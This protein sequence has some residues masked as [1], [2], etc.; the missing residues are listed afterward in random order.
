MIQAYG[1]GGIGEVEAALD[2]FS[3]SAAETRVR[4]NISR[5]LSEF[6]FLLVKSTTASFLGEPVPNALSHLTTLHQRCLLERPRQ[7]H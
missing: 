4:S 7:A 1:Q 5:C 2:H 6:A 3:Q